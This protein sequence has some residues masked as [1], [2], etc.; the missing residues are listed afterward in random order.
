MA[1]PD[2]PA[3]ERIMANTIEEI[4]CGDPDALSGRIV[5]ALAG[6]EYCVLPANG[7]EDTALSSQPFDA[8]TAEMRPL[9][10]YGDGLD[11]K[12]ETL[13]QAGTSPT[14]CPC[15]PGDR[16]LWALGDLRSADPE[17]QNRGAAPRVTQ[18]AP[19]VFNGA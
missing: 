15:D 17:R 4:A 3:I 2:S 8:L 18:L 1:N 9:D 10:T 13:E 19:Q 14:I 16:W 12:F 5:A 11:W 6:A 7:I